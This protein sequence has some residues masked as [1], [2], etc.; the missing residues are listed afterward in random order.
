KKEIFINSTSNEIRIA[1]TEDNKLTEY[2]TE[3]SDNER[4]VGDIYLGK[5]AKVMKGIRAAF[6][7]IGFQ[8]DAFLHFSDVSTSD[9]YYSLL[10]E[11]IDEEDDDDEEQPE[12][13]KDNNPN[14][15][16]KGRIQKNSRPPGKFNRD[17]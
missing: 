14:Q 1:I 11:D 16:A 3:S 13:P 9:E 7:D 12:P 8:Q 2:F 10:G 15:K 5:V 17:S 6:I 4:N